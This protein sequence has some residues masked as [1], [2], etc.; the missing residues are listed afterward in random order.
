MLKQQ[1][2]RVPPYQRP[3]AWEKTQ[4]E[5]LFR[6]IYDAKR[7]NKTEPYFLGTVV[8]TSDEDGPLS[9]VDGQQRIVTTA[10]LISAIRNYFNA[11]GDTEREQMITTD[12]LSTRGIRDL[13][14]VPRLHLV[15]D[16]REFFQ[17]NVVEPRDLGRGR[18]PGGLGTTQKR[19]QAASIVARDFVSGITDRSS[20]PT[21]DLLDLLDFIQ[22]KAVLVSLDVS[23]EANAYV[24]FE[25]L[26]DRGLD[27]TVA[28]LLKNYLFRLT[29]GLALEECQS[30][31]ANMRALIT[32]EYDEGE[33][34]QFVR[35]AWISEYGLVRHKELYNAIKSRIASQNDALT[36]IRSLV[37]KARLYAAFRN[38]G[39]SIWSKYSASVREALTLFE[40]AGVTQVRPLLL[41]VFLNF[42][43]KE[44]NK[45]LP[46]M[47]AWSVRLLVFGSGGSGPLE[48]N[49]S[50]RARE[51]SDR[52][53]STA[54][55]LHASFKILPNDEEFKEAF[56]RAQ[57]SKASIGRWYLAK[58][59]ITRSGNTEK[60]ITEDLS[61][62]N[63]EHVLPINP[64]S[65]WRIP[66]DDVG[67]L[68]NRL[69]NQ[70]LMDSKANVK[71]GN[72]SFAEKREVFRLSS[73][74]LTR[75]LSDFNTWGADEIQARQ[76]R[77]AELAVI[78]WR[79]E[80]A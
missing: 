3:Y 51:V 77:L 28:D 10:I 15:H 31:W 41:A 60:I 12:Y 5:E 78:T 73:I 39:S 45:T 56:S 69:G 64:D 22:E 14:H 76:V 34:R 66:V 38:S 2:L 4:V 33:I 21:G 42:T 46:M 43:E 63:L 67:K 20:D 27:L 44:V 58:L 55:Q 72:A 53:I 62:A 71:I 65:S 19:I 11:V 59:E 52:Q 32:S 37:D 80:P 7:R 70:T 35:Q 26:N 54:R 36:Y 68:V 49:Y 61:K 29:S 50:A 24:I 48:D 30:A 8:L 13:K 6:D 23:S 25:V 74:E 17:K 40:V 57:V 75:D 16:D 9:I 79:N 47:A 1:R 18:L